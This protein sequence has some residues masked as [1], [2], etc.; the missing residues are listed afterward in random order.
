M[1]LVDERPQMSEAKPE[2]N[3]RG[4]RVAS[5]IADMVSWLHYFEKKKPKSERRTIAQIVDPLLREDV[6]DLYEAHL[7]EI[8]KIAKA[9]GQEVQQ[10]QVPK[11]PTRG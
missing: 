2:E 9:L 5:D 1:L 6:T 7:P 11:P 8:R 4:I 10:G 3:D